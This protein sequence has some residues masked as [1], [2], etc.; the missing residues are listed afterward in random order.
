M[1]PGIKCHEVSPYCL[2]TSTECRIVTPAAAL[3]ALSSPASFFFFFFFFFFFLSL[4]GWFKTGLTKTLGQLMGARE[5]LN[6]RK[7][8]F[9]EDKPLRS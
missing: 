1:L 3:A 6:G 2:T 5:S 7:K 4:S 8:K 9:G